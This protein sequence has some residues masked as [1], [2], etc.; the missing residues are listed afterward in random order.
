MPLLLASD[1]IAIIAAL[2]VRQYPGLNT[3]A[4]RHPACL[5][6]DT[7]CRPSVPASAFPLAEGD[8]GP[9]HPDPIHNHLRP[10]RANPHRLA[11]GRFAFHLDES[12]LDPDRLVAEEDK[13]SRLP[14]MAI[15]AT[16]AARGISVDVSLFSNRRS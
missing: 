14:A 13:V 7:L 5:T 8:A 1:R 16:D 4:F 10:L 6:S 15:G 12:S 2:T 11:Q 9:T 3:Q